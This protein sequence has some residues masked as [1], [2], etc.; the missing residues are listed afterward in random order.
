MDRD[1]FVEAALGD[2]CLQSRLYAAGQER[3]RGDIFV[4]PA[5]SRKQPDGMP[6]SAP[7]G[8]QQA[9]QRRRE[10]NI[11][12]LGALAALDVDQHAGAVDLRNTQLD[13]FAEA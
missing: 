2:S 9:E 7:V 11:A 8:A 3:V 10:R 13:A 4:E 5:S 6:V 12:V 1:M